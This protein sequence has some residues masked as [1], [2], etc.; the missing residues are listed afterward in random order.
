MRKP[1]GSQWLF[2]AIVRGGPEAMTAEA[3]LANIRVMLVGITNVRALLRA[4][5]PF[6]SL[7]TSNTQKHNVPLLTSAYLVS[8]T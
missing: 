5:A 7:L 6:A 3:M 8:L 1:V 2:R 4:N